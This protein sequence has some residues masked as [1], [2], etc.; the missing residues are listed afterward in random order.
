MKTVHKVRALVTTKR[1]RV[2]AIKGNADHVLQL[3]DDSVKP[4][5]DLFAAIMRELPEETGRTITITDTVN[6]TK[7]KRNGV[8]EITTL[9]TATATGRTKRKMTKREKSR[10]LRP[11]T[12]GDADKLAKALKRKTKRYDRSAAKRDLRLVRAALAA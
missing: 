5:E 12:F 3:P 4:G 7:I 1:G 2:I 11:V 9:F 10:G 6:T 8:V